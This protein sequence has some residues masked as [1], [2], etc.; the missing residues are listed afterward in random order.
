LVVFG[1]VT[2]TQPCALKLADLGIPVSY[3][4]QDGEF[5]A[6]LVG[7]LQGGVRVRILHFQAALE[8]ETAS[9]VA[10][11]FVAA[12]IHNCRRLIQTRLADPAQQLLTLESQI[13]ECDTVNQVIELE[14]RAA[15]TYF[16]FFPVMLRNPKFQFQGRNRR[17]PKDPVNAALSFGYTLLANACE[18]A[19]HAAG[20]DPD[21]GFLH[22]PRPGRASLALDLME[23]FRAPVVDA[24]VLNLFNKRVL[25]ES[26]FEP[27][28]GGEG[29]Y[30]NAV[31]RPLFLR[32]YER[33][34]HQA[35]AH[36]NHKEPVPIGLLPLI[37]A[38]SL[39]HMF[40]HPE[41]PYFGFRA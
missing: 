1:G 11:Q 6:R 9:F 8:Q 24:L 14:A 20:L 3:L 4:S 28:P 17:P 25:N 30:L 34:R 37:Q 32:E 12:K 41:A 16:R 35:I 5:R 36:P 22:Q 13:M 40:R 26:H 39:A 2:L 15:A 10:G 29:V 7:P 38:K 19:L 33:R 21:M 18:G 31:G 27:A 23:E